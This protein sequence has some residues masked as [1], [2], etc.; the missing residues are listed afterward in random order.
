MHSPFNCSNRANWR[1]SDINGRGRRTI[2]GITLLTAV[3][4]QRGESGINGRGRRTTPGITL[5]TAVT[6]QRGESGI[7][8]RG[9]RTTPRITL[10]TAVT[11]QRGESGMVGEKNHPRDNPLNSR[12][13]AKGGVWYKWQGKKNHPKHTFDPLNPRQSVKRD[14][15]GQ[16][17][18]RGLGRLNS[19]CRIPIICR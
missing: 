18:R 2:P 14:C 3:T 16:L 6:G 13:R 1:E 15:K 5:L 17:S 19:L 10:L 7:N 4:G 12:N 8:G 11:G 9:R